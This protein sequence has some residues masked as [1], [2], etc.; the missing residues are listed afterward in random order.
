MG[1]KEGRKEGREEGRIEGK[2]EGKLEVY[3]NLKNRDFDDQTMCSM[4]G[5][6]LQK[7]QQFKKRLS[8]EAL[9]SVQILIHTIQTA[10]CIMTLIR[11]HETGRSA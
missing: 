4:L 8:E 1:K 11:R 2:D 5:I 3:A 7:L 10:I 6:T 9:M